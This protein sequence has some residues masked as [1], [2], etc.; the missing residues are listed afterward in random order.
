MGQILHRFSLFCS[1]MTEAVS[2]A[3]LTLYCVNK[4]CMRRLA[5]NM[6]MMEHMFNVSK[7]GTLLLQGEAVVNICYTLYH[8]R[9]EMTKSKIVIESLQPLFSCKAC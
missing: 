1:K 7:N 3:L 2:I 6:D 8:C 4:L 5:A 9:M